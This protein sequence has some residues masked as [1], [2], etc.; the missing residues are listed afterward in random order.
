M[1]AKRFEHMTPITGPEE[2]DQ[3]NATVCTTV[4]A[5]INLNAFPPTT[6]YDSAF[7]RPDCTTIPPVERSTATAAASK[8]TLLHLGTTCR[9]TPL[10]IIAEKHDSNVSTCHFLA[11]PRSKHARH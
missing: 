6:D 9:S 7:S 5:N 2:P 10:A 3:L 4:R 1:D 11:G 8:A